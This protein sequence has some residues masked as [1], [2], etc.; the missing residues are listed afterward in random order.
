MHMCTH[1]CCKACQKKLTLLAPLLPPKN[2]QAPHCGTA[3]L[4]EQLETNKTGKLVVVKASSCFTTSKINCNVQLYNC[5]ALLVCHSACLA[6]NARP[7]TGSFIH[8]HVET[9]IIGI[10]SRLHQNK[11]LQHNIHQHTHYLKSVRN[12]FLINLQHGPVPPEEAANC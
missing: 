12:S 8:Q 1:A 6:E 4:R 7:G 2:K 9:F 5:H 11:E 3:T 10:A